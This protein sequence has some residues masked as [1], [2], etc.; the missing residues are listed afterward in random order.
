MDA[1]AGEGL[2]P[3]SGCR[4]IFMDQ[5]REAKRRKLNRFAGSV[6]MEVG[7][8]RAKKSFTW[9]YWNVPHAQDSRNYSG[10]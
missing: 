4:V 9:L 8:P 1:I 2:L 10:C 5:F 6:W 3:M 7:K